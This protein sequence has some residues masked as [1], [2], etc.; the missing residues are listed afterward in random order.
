MRYL[1]LLVFASCA[2]TMDWGWKAADIIA[3]VPP[4]I[5]GEVVSVIGAT[6]IG[7][8]LTGGPLAGG[9][10]LLSGVAAWLARSANKKRAKHTDI[11]H[12][13]VADIRDRLPQKK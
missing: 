8:T 9:A 10:V 13:E 7:A 3:A 11:L 1:F 12:A 4:E 6:L 2:G 5:A